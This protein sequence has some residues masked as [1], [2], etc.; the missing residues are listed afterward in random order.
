MPKIHLLNFPDFSLWNRIQ[1]QIGIL[2]LGYACILLKAS[3]WGS[4]LGPRLFLWPCFLFY[5]SVFA[6][7][8]AS[9]VQILIFG[10]IHDSIFNIPLGL[11]SF[12]WVSWYWFMAK[13]RRHLV[14]SQTQTLWLIFAAS[15][16][17][18][19]AIEYF[20]LIKTIKFIDPA[21]MIIET[22]FNIGFFPIGMHYFH[23]F[24]IRLGRLR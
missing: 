12:I 20:F 23:Q 13:Q 18:Q 1:I 6:T 3:Y 9:I 24:F 21:F 22:T 2:L 11:S 14:K 19:N 10:L 7:P 4:I 16:S 8:I 15:L 5:I 17:A